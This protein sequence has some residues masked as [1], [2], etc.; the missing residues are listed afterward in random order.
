MA[1]LRE[2]TPFRALL[3][4]RK[5]HSVFQP[6]VS[7]TDRQVLG[8]EAFIRGPKGHPL[9]NP[10]GLF[11]AAEREGLGT[12]LELMARSTTLRYFAELGFPGKLFLNINPACL[13]LR[14]SRAMKF[15]RVLRPSNSRA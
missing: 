3:L 1:A 4:Q 2:I 6:I 7:I 5:L 11:G 13:T 14:E 8:L 10:G 9:E 15:S 12:E